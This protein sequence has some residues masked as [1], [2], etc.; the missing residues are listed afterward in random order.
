MVA[1]DPEN[2]A[3]RAY[4][5]GIDYRYFKYD[6]VSQSKRQVGSTFKPFVYTAAIENGMEPCTYFSGERSYLYRHGRLDAKKCRR[7]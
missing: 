6:H 1:L 4:I 3:V 2:G 5:G 7:T